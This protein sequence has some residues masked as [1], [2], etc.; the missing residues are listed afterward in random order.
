MLYLLLCFF[1][2]NSSYIMRTKETESNAVSPED[3]FKGCRSFTPLYIDSPSEIYEYIVPPLEYLT[4]H[5]D[6]SVTK[7][8]CLRIPKGFVIAFQNSI[9]VQANII[10]RDDDNNIFY[11]YASDKPFGAACPHDGYCDYVIE[12]NGTTDIIIGYGITTEHEINVK[13]NPFTVTGSREPFL[14]LK[15][16]SDSLGT[17]ANLQGTSLNVNLNQIYVML[18]STVTV[19]SNS[20]A[21]LSYS[22]LNSNKVMVFTDLFNEDSV[23]ANSVVAG[24]SYAFPSE[25]FELLRGN[26]MSDGEYKA[27]GT[28]DVSILPTV[29]QISNWPDLAFVVEGGKVFSKSPEFINSLKTEPTD[30]VGSSLSTGAIVGIVI[31][32]VVVLIIIIVVIYCCCKKG[33]CGNKSEEPAA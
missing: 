19:E 11:A 22:Y 33:C 4:Y 1:N 7:G 28:V 25:Y 18:A 6:Y 10:G 16:F 20:Y 12:P 24:I 26:P 31:A 13:V 15:E 30:F 5:L 21:Q 3:Y 27:K 32:A 8:L 23:T 17:Y 2:I 9:N 29:S 14:V